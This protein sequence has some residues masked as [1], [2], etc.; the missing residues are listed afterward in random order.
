MLIGG[1][2]FDQIGHGRAHSMN[3]PFQVGHCISIFGLLVKYY[4]A[5]N[6]KVDK[7]VTS[8]AICLETPYC[9]HQFISSLVYLD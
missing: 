9:Q 8:W 2:Y 6:L 4:Q 3:G 1:A 5:L 7:C